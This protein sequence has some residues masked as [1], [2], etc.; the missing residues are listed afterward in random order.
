MQEIGAGD[1][2]LGRVVTGR[3]RR[4]G[5]EVAA[6]ARRRAVDRSPRGDDL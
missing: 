4:E 2:R 6:G 1:A 3:Q 5:G